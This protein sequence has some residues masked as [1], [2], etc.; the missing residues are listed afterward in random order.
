MRAELNNKMIGHYITGELQKKTA[1]ASSLVLQH[2][3]LLRNVLAFSFECQK[4][5]ENSS[6]LCLHRGKQWQLFLCRAEETHAPG[7]SVDTGSRAAVF[8]LTISSYRVCGH[9]FAA[10]TQCVV[11]TGAQ[12]QP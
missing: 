6:T 4:Y 8:Y 10:V 2:S 12:L 9:D 11:Q 3:Q 7:N 5:C 1:Q